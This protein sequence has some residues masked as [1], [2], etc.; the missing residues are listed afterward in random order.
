MSKNLRGRRAFMF[1]VVDHDEVHRL[2]PQD[3]VSGILQSFSYDATAII[4]D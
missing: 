3:L 2:Y 1:T 4:E